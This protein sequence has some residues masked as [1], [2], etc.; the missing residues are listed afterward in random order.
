MKKFRVWL[1]D[2]VEPLGGFWWYCLQDENGYLF[3]E[4]YPNEERDTIEQ[5]IA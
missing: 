2:S 3:D 5:Y 1:E 4:A